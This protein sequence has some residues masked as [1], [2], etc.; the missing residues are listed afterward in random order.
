[1]W[2]V[3]YI[4]YIHIERVCIQVLES[5]HICIMIFLKGKNF[6][7]CEC[8]NKIVIWKILDFK[9]TGKFVPDFS[10]VF[11]NSK[12]FKVKTSFNKKLILG[13][14]V[15][16]Y[17][18]SIKSKLQKNQAQIC[19]Y[20]S[21]FFI[22]CSLYFI[23]VQLRQSNCTKIF[24][25]ERNNIFLKKYGETKIVSIYL[26]VSIYLHFLYFF[27]FSLAYI[28][29]KIYVHGFFLQSTCIK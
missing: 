29:G 5:I 18:F 15:N 20:N 11:V 9:N 1:M 6:K 26:Q 23:C 7:N 17:K 10:K 19:K 22:F 4:L 24:L 16:R 13:P 2:L 27:Y 8:R 25:W 12:A 28:G 21:L 14:K 3:L